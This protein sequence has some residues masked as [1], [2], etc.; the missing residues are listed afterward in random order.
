MILRRARGRLAGVWQ[1][2]TGSIDPGETALA[3]ARR[4]V[5]EETGL[6]PRR[7]WRLEGVTTFMNAPADAIELLPLFAAE[8]GAEE[9]VRISSEH[10]ACE[11]LSVRAA[12]RRF[13]WDSQR[14]ALAAVGREILRG[15]AQA[16]AL[17][18][19]PMDP[20]R[21]MRRASGRAQGSSTRT[22]RK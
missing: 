22:R 16:R 8:I 12:G 1:P 11:F 2:V 20:A 3:A 13:L 15:G 14:R 6:V 17:A 5:E 7:W 10:D 19:D 4:E 9:A 18:L 21:P